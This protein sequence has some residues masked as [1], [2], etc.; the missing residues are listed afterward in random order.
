MF[1]KFLSKPHR[2]ASPD[3]VILTF[4]VEDTVGTHIREVLVGDAGEREAV[5]NL[6]KYLAAL[7]KKYTGEKP[8]LL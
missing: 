2:D 8:V 3:E 1:S 4:T 5:M 7:I 6:I